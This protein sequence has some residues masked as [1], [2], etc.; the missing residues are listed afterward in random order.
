MTSINACHRDPTTRDSGPKLYPQF[1]LFG[2]SITQGSHNDL[3]PPLSNYYLRRLDIINRGFSGYTA[4]MG[5]TI[6]PRFFP[7][8]T[9]APDTNVAH[10]RLMTVFF[11]ANDACLPGQP[12]HVSLVAYKHALGQI[13]SYEGVRLHAT[14][15]I[16]ITPPPIDEYQLWD[17]NQSRSA[18]NTALYAEACRN[19]A[20]SLSLPC[21]DLWSVFMTKA[22]WKGPGSG[23]K[24]IGSKE[25]ERSRVLNELLDDGLHLSPQGYN[26]LWHELRALIES[27]LS[28]EVAGGLPMVYPSYT[29]MLHLDT[30]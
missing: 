10:V 21:I 22:G 17:G 6:L 26:V 29:D 13:A 19:V 11:G 15:I 4:P 23:E 3:V 25:R 9:P 18:V 28:S 12:Q 2:D 1:L 16:F 14:K 27:E 8:T 20:A 7:A 30:K 24:L 5:L